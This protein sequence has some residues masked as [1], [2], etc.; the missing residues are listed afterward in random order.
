MHCST[1]FLVGS[2]FI[3]KNSFVLMWALLSRFKQYL[4]HL[5]WAICI[6]FDLIVLGNSTLVKKKKQADFQNW[7]SYKRVLTV[8]IISFFLQFIYPNPILK[9]Y[10]PFPPS[11]IPVPRK[12]IPISKLKKRQIPVPILPLPHALNNHTRFFM[13][14]KCCG[15]DSTNV[16]IPLLESLN[17]RLHLIPYL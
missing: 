10:F 4:I 5:F 6:L 3:F 12:P 14:S 9:F 16:T 17:S 7:V 2:Q 1:L 15:L 8:F 13:D 11:D